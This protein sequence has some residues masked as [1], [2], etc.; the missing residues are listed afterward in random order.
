MNRADTQ[1]ELEAA[2]LP[3]AEAEQAAPE[4]ITRREL[5]EAVGFCD[6]TFD[7]RY[8]DAMGD[9][10]NPGGPRARAKIHLPTLRKL[11]AERDAATVKTP[12]RP[13]TPE[14]FE[15]FMHDYAI[16]EFLAELDAADEK[17]LPKGAS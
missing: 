12:S 10:Y 6:A 15:A 8:R 2:A 11:I 5:P 16:G 7:R 4:W 3:E 17:V 1:A 14:E 9:G 13:L